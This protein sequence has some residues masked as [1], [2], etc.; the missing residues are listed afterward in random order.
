MQLN[1]EA[2]LETRIYLKAGDISTELAQVLAQVEELDAFIMSLATSED[3]DVR[4][5]LVRHLAAKRDT[6]DRLMKETDELP[7]DFRGPLA[8]YQRYVT[9]TLHR[10]ELCVGMLY[11]RLPRA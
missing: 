3:N 9:D 10:T 5:V 8:N 11:A 1:Q 4:H 6:L 2:E 7:E